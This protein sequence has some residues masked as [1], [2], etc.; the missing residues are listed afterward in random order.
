[1]VHQTRRLWERAEKH[2]KPEIWA[3]LEST[4]V[5]AGAEENWEALFR[6]VWLFRR[7]ATDVAEALGYQNPHSLD[8]SVM[9]RLHQIKNMEKNHVKPG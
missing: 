7:I 9:A 6:T 3:E 4:Y 5:G 2:T 1:L 8:N